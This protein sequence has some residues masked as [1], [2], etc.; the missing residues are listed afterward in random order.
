MIIEVSIL[1]HYLIFKKCRVFNIDEN[2]ETTDSDDDVETT[3]TETDVNDDFFTKPF[4]FNLIFDY[5]GNKK[6]SLDDEYRDLRNKYNLPKKP[7]TVH[8]NIRNYAATTI[9]TAYKN[10]LILHAKPRI[11][12]LLK[13]LLKERHS[14]LP[15]HIKQQ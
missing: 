12:H 15:E 3:D 5:L 7:Y 1:A 14:M 9:E 2:V 11:E 4:D 6:N 10:N 13:N 8:Q